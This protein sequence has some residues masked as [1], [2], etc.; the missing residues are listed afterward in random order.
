[1]EAGQQVPIVI[2]YYDTHWATNLALRWQS[3]HTPI[4]DIPASHLYSEMIEVGAPAETSP[5]VAALSAPIPRSSRISPVSIEGVRR[6]GDL[7]LATR[8]I[9]GALTVQD[10]NAGRFHLDLPLTPVLP[11]LTLLRTTDG[12]Y[13]T[14]LTSWLPTIVADT[15]ENVELRLG[16]SLLLEASRPGTVEIGELGCGPSA[17]DATEVRMRQRFQK[18]FDHPGYFRVV[19]KDRRGV[20]AGEFDVAVLSV[21]L[22]APVASEIG[23]P[24]VLSLPSS[25]P[26]RIALSANDA[27]LLDVTH[28]LAGDDAFA[29]LA[30]PVQRGTPAIVARVRS[31][32][33]VLGIRP[34]DEFTITS[35]IV[36]GYTIARDE[37]GVGRGKFGFRMIPV[38][39]Y[40]A[41]EVEFLV[42]GITV[43]GLSRF[44]VPASDVGSDG[45]WQGDMVVNGFGV[46]CH[47]VL[48]TQP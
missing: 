26:E 1:M 24:K 36:T 7:V 45:H 40:T 11:T 16:D 29:L 32:G 33:A 23:F 5:T 27:T 2:E 14:G 39:P 47:R 48:V 31:T 22:S 37:Y 30:K 3:E 20:V 9:L 12:Q 34:I 19:Q 35:D 38:V 18:R 25:T 46:T 17:V 8:N 6:W 15:T 4:E 43:D 28:L 10:I 42:P 13:A 41:I 44:T 21:D